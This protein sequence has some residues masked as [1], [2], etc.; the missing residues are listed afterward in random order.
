MEVP[1]GLAGDHIDHVVVL[2]LENHSFDQMLGCMKAVYPQLEGIDPQNLRSN[3]DDKGKPFQQRPTTERQ[4]LLDPHHEVQHVA[5][6]L[7]HGNSGF[8]SDFT[9]CY[10][11]KGDEASGFIM[12]YYPKD[13]LPALH[14]LAQDFTICDHWFASLPGPTW[15][16]RF[17]ALTGTSKGRVNMPDDGT[18]KADLPGYFQQDQDTIFDRLTEKGVH[19]KVYFHD[20]PQSWV[21]TQQ[22]TP[23]NAARYFYIREFFADARGA[24][25]EFPSFCFIEPDFMGINENDD[26][27]PHDIMKAEK[28]IADVFNALRANDELW[29]STLLVVFYDEHGG[30]YDHVTPPAAVPPDDHCDEY[31]FNQLGVRVPAL[32]ISPWV[33]K[34]V[35][36]TQFDHTSLL[37][38]LTDKWQLRPLPSRRMA[39]ANS[40]RSAISR[41][42]PRTNTIARIELTP[43]QLRPP[44]PAKEEETFGIVNAHHSALQQ[45]SAHLKVAL[46]E[47][48]S[49]ELPQWYAF[50]SRAVEW[51][52]TQLAYFIEWLMEGCQWALGHLYA[53]GG[54]EASFA[55]PD[56]LSVKHAWEKNSVANFLMRQK[57]R[58]I[59]GLAKRIHDDG[60]PFDVQQHALRTLAAITGRPFHLYD[61]E[62][63][64]SWLR[65][66]GH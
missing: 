5:A 57:P 63:A 49:E 19:W 6:Q 54:F 22:R 23:H 43:D 20:I 25:E 8:V 61:T 46:W 9:K 32:L 55:E 26:H 38:Y 59:R 52:K 29:R 12:G 2:V 4:M 37:R 7:A 48:I 1:N 35:V 66:R 47:Q 60:T 15:P 24:A 16:N 53:Q 62:H 30:F 28:L 33:E 3:A 13:F 10:P 39:A 17:F 40:I 18:H 50:A 65:Q 27:P 44:D 56:K 45:L 14:A 51:I 58:A 36:S 64:K 31:S 11:D 41:A 42:Q 21:L 34:A